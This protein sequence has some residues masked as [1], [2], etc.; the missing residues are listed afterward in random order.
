MT[1]LTH[2]EAI[3]ELNDVPDWTLHPKTITR[4]YKFG[5]F[6]KSIAFVDQIARRAQKLN[7]HPDI[8]VRFDQ[9]TLVLTTHDAGGLTETDFTL[10]EQC[11]KEFDTIVAA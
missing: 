9:V 1:A 8:D 6:L 4:T 7:H 10:A 11:D 5:G 3:E 2:D